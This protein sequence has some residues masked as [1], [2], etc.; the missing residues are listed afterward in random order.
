M[1]GA[2]FDWLEYADDVVVPE[3]MAIAV[4]HN[5]TGNVVVRQQGWPDEDVVI[6]LERRN[7]AALAHAILEAA[8]FDDEPVALLA[9]PSTSATEPELELSVTKPKDPA[10]AERSRRYRNRKR[11]TERDIRDI[12]RDATV[13]HRDGD[14]DVTAVEP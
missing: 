1:T 8:E 12:D 13:T 9:P 3:Q 4:Y 2:E 11:D 14:L 10:A 7:A 5:P 6:I